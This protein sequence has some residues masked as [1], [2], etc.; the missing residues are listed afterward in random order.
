VPRV[1]RCVY[2]LTILA[3]LA[4]SERPAPG[5][6]NAAALRAGVD[7]VAD[8]LLTA[9]RTNASDSL[10]VLMA[11]DVVLMPPNEPV[12][13]GKAAVRDWYDQLLTQLR[14]SNL[15]I[16]ERE[17]L[18]GDEWAT[19]LATFEWTLAPVAGGPAVTDR[20]HYVQVWHREP[21]G[22]WLF[23]RELWNST[24]PAVTSSSEP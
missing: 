13:E 23:A 5:T 10:L 20:G 8:R 7:S 24:T 15:A 11:D 14:T 16:T 17:V 21:D 6:A 2:L 4:C 9:L 1:T 22:R 12:L 19:E 3:T 18:I